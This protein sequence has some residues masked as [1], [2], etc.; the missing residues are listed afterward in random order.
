MLARRCLPLFAALGAAAAA[1]A[2][3]PM[4][5]QTADERIRDEAKNA[6]LALRFRGTTAAECRAWQKEFAAKLRAALGPFEPPKA[7]KV[8]AVRKVEHDDHTFED[9]ILEAKG[10]PALPLCVLTPKGAAEGKHA[11]IL[12]LHG[13]GPRGH[14]AIGEGDAG[15]TLVRK[16]YVVVAPCFTPFGVRLGTEDYG[17]QDACGI[18]FIR[19][20]LLGKLLIA[21]NLRDSLWALEFLASRPEVDANRLGCA[22]LSYGGRMAMLTAALEPRIK[23]AVVAGA[24]NLMQERIQVK[25]SCGA[26]VIPGLLKYGDVPEIGS[27]I[28]PRPA[29]WQWGAEDS[30]IKANDA[31]DAAR[32][33]RAAYK[34]LGA[35]ENL[36]I[37]RFEGGHSWHWEGAL[38]EL[39]KALRK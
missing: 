31:E 9:L 37:D 8:T 12:A 14:L 33:M 13:H 36:V 11:G 22:G 30:L 19:L 16:G 2:G 4:K 7:W 6:P 18:T 28:A 39:H 24:L 15:R 17:K 27:L 20:Q 25:Y 1:F 34:A 29:V 23:V 26:Q 32:R 5:P 21:E 10:H 35:A 3:E 38:P